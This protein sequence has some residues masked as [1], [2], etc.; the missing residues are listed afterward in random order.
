MSCITHIYACLLCKLY[1]LNC[2]MKNAM[3]LCN[4][5]LSN[6]FCNKVEMVTTIELCLLMVDSKFATDL[7]SIYGSLYMQIYYII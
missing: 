5:Q 3:I 1:L 7:Y 6:K 4:L 2:N